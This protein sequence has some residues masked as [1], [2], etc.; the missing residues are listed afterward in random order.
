MSIYISGALKG[1]KNITLARA[2][3][4]AAASILR[5]IGLEPY[6]PHHNTDPEAN[7]DVSPDDVFR[8]DMEA[9]NRSTAVI[10][11]LDEPSLGVGLEIGIFASR[12]IPLLALCEQGCD[13]SRFAEGFL[14][15]NNC[16]VT[17]YTDDIEEIITAWAAQYFPKAKLRA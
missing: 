17:R 5:N 11:F 14:A 2:K 9:I 12:G 6:L 15:K 16:E 3:Y 13:L 8:Q 1:S 7:R 10:L 4:E